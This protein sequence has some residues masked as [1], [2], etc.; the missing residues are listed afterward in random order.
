MTKLKLALISLLVLLTAFTIATRPAEVD[1]TQ[2]A[3]TLTKTIETN[4]PPCLQMYYY[5]E[6]YADS[7]DVPRS[8]AFGLAYAETHYRGP[9]H[10]QYN[11]KQKSPSGAMGPMQIMPSTAK[12]IDNA[13]FISIPKLR[14]DIK[15][16]V[17]LSMKLVRQ[18]Y[19]KYGNW[20]IVFGC[21]NTG[22]PC[23]NSY[24]KNVVNYEPNW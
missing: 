20:E 24:A 3:I 17:R 1:T 4:D 22:K 2:H 21:Y 12:M 9:F 10:W 14:T 23:I 19:D 5:I 6:H 11:H 13:K 8:Y 16:N 15:Y 7:F 18:L